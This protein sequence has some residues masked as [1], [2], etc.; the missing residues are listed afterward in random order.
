MIR[1]LA[2]I[3]CL[4]SMALPATSDQIARLYEAVGT[5]KLI[6]ILSEE[7]MEQSEAL[8]MDMFPG[9][10]GVGWSATVS[11]IY[12][13]TRL[14]TLFVTE[15]E[16]ELEGT[17]VKGLLDFYASELGSR[18]SLLEV[19]ARRAFMSDEVEKAAVLAFERL[20][21]S[22]SDRLELLEQ[23][24]DTTGWI[25][26]NVAGALNSNLAF[27]QGLASGQGF[28]MTEDQM[29]SDVWGQEEGIRED[30]TDWV[31]GFMTFAY[32]TLS[33]DELRAY[34]MLTASDAG[35]D[36][37]RALFAG[38]DAIFMEVSYELGAAASLFSMGD[39]L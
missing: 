14:K 2:F 28:E 12:D 20:K 17:D 31:F 32:E 22:G 18:V 13:A 16:A 9:R 24:A 34:T 15:F 21:E 10:G 26:R 23:L 19:E 33:D 38:Y 36:L 29:L 7:G 8:R 27:Y 6:Q 5:E 39:E 1:L 35:R 37:N 30:T 11:T 4:P 25:D 3:I